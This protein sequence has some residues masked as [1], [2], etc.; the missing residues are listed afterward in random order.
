MEYKF[1]NNTIRSQMSKS[2]KDYQKFQRQLFMFQ[3]YN[4]KLF[5]TFRKN[6]KVTEYNF[7]NF[8]FRWEMIKSTT[9]SHIFALT[10]FRRLPFIM[11][12]IVFIVEVDCYVAQYRPRLDV[13]G[14]TC[15]WSNARCQKTSSLASFSHLQ[16][17]IPCNSICN[18]HHKK[19]KRE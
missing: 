12:E 2:T 6:V 4:K 17:T 5:L 9:V 3:R 10:L 14:A 7:G 13:G 15:P 18:Q 19:F 11:T 1:R 16:A 8:T